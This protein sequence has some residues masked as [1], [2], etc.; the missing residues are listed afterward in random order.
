MY[1]IG[2]KY[3]EVHQILARLISGSESDAFYI[4]STNFDFIYINR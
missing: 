4:H 2:V 1:I 3:K